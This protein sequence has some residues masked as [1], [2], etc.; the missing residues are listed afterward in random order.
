MLPPELRLRIKS[1]SREINK[2]KRKEE[3]EDNAASVGGT[4][5]FWMD[6]GST[7]TLEWIRRSY[8]CTHL[9]YYVPSRDESQS[10]VSS[11]SIASAA[12]GIELIA[13]NKS[14]SHFEGKRASIGR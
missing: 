14:V 3:F 1:K 10:S 11:S 2:T 8:I 12:K 9:A 5:G 6:G 13:V 7:G 4:G